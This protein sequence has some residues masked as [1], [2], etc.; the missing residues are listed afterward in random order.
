M[1]DIHSPLH[2][3]EKFFQENNK[4]REVVELIC[5]SIWFTFESPCKD[6]VHAVSKSDSRVAFNSCLSLLWNTMEALLL[7][8]FALAFQVASSSTGFYFSIVSIM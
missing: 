1:I 7:T 5:S 8:Y 4:S 2:P 3:T 6:V